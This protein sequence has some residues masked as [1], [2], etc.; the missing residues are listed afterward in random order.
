MQASSPVD[1]VTALR[2]TLKPSNFSNKKN[3]KIKTSSKLLFQKIKTI[4]KIK[5]EA[6]RQREREERP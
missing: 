3:K 2:F 1:I 4:K 5:S 6:E